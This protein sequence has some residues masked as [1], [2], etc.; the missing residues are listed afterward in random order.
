MIQPKILKGTRDFAPEMMAKRDHVMNKIRGVFRKYGYDTIETPVIEY[1]ETILGK[2][3]DEGD[4]LTYHFQD[5]GDRHIALRY[6]QTVPFARY[7]ADNWQELPSPFKR[8]QISRVWRADKPQKGR[9][10]E[11]YQCDIDIIGTNSLLADLELIQVMQD[12]MVDLG[13]TD[14]KIQFND[15]KLMNSIL[16]AADV[17]DKNRVDVIRAL[18]KLDKIGADKVE[19]LLVENGLDASLAANL[20]QTVLADGSNHDKVAALA[21]FE[22]STIKEILALSEAAGLD[23]TKLELNLALARGLDYYTGLIFEVVLT[24]SSDLG[25]VCAGG[26]YDNL[27]SMFCKEEF[28]GTG[29]AFGFE[30]MM[31]ALLERK[32]LDDVPLNAQVLVVQF[33]KA[34]VIDNLKLV[35]QLRQAGLATELSFEDSK[36]GKQFKYAD[37]K[38]IPF[39]LVQGS[40]EL[41]NGVVVLKDMKTGDQTDYP[42]DKISEVLLNKVS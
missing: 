38:N 21:D 18:D 6:D 14:Y 11:F 23:L 7:Y 3:G 28:S 5:H 12:V 17:S 30:R 32:M 15:R 20:M 27:C 39:V 36:L 8:Y 1:A 33:G 41:D 42:L 22:I 29:V 24:N 13:L 26:R 16:E 2:Y 40:E 4:K 25:T 19:K 10:R 35:T 9:L 34:T 37:K 31:E